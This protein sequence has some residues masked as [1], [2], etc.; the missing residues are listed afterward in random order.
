M[1]EK[2]Q[3][4]SSIIV[5]PSLMDGSP[6][7][8][9]AAPG[10]NISED[11]AERFASNIRASWE[12][13]AP[14]A[15]AAPVQL[16]GQGSAPPA[17]TSDSPD[18]PTIV[19]GA[20]TRR[21]NLL[22]FAAVLLGFVAFTLLGIRSA[23][24]QPAASK[25]EEPTGAGAAEAVEEIPEP[26]P[27]P[28]PPQGGPSE[29]PVAAPSDLAAGGAAGAEDTT[30]HGAEEGV[31]AEG[32]AEVDLAAAAEVAA[33]PVPAPEPAAPTTVHIRVRTSPTSATLRLDGK[34]IAN[35]Y[36]ADVPP[37]GEH[38]LEATARGHRKLSRKVR[39][40]ADRNLQFNLE[41]RT[42][43]A[44]KTSAAS[45]PKPRARTPLQVRPKSVPKPAEKSK[46][47]KGAGF[48]SE[49]PY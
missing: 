18:F 21:R 31:T 9:G 15:G 13:P 42:A 23:S 4:P 20:A 26:A 36:D 35:P 16:E 24:E 46:S 37:S 44:P 41:K 25:H 32:E 33:E 27:E 22:I 38:V 19:P 17:S 49:D 14:A 10:K 29:E 6:E 30:E 39:F 3:Q 12:P 45:A 11:D 5:D 2:D 48:V 1:T 34:P 7:E 43:A 8:D 40:D 28:D 47:S